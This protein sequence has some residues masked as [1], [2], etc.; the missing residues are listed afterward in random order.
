MTVHACCSHDLLRFTQAYFYDAF[1]L[2]R[3]RMIHKL[4][5]N[6]VIEEQLYTPIPTLHP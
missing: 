2:D 3:S 4:A 1:V 5:Y 6:R